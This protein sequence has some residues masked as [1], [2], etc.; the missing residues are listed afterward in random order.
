M[1]QLGQ[2]L[3]SIAR[4]NPGIVTL[5]SA[6]K[7]AAVFSAVDLLASSAAELPVDAVRVMSADRT[8]VTPTPALVADP[9][10]LVEP[11]VWVYQLVHSMATDGNAFGKIVQ[12]DRD[13]LP[14]QI[15]TLHP[16]AVTNR[17][18]E[19]GVAA[20]DVE[21]KSMLRYPFGDLFHIPGK[22]VEA[23]SPFG[24]SPVQQASDALA[25][26]QYAE[27]FGVNFFADGAH[28]TTYVSAAEAVDQKNAK[29]LK[30]KIMEATRGNREPLVLGANFDLKQIQTN[31][32]DSQ[33]IDLLRFEI[34]Q[35][36]R[37][38]RVPPS[39]IYAAVS[40]QAVTYS[41]VSQGDLQYLKHSLQGYLSRIERAWSRLLP[42]RI[43]VKFNLNA[44]LRSDVETRNKVYDMRLKNGSMT[45]NE[46]RALED[47]APLV[48]GQQMSAREIAEVIQ[49]IY[50]GVDVVLTSDEAR[51]IINNAGAGLPIPGGINNLLP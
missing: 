34:E 29:A 14:V 20:V 22:M 47:E 51:Q 39:M 45:V 33:F 36:A 11:D 24:L 32:D 38:W 31:P 43:V 37:F 40:G 35:V 23:G 18:V 4:S 15:E 28:P 1:Q 16:S 21:G 3:S 7:N 50:L 13:G 48:D 44:L 26:S 17:R 30:D 49:K 25:A 41:N 12:V 42:D 46:V 27:R 19:K 8:P 5:D 2:Q 6:L 9:S 10:A